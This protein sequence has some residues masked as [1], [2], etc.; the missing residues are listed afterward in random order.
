MFFSLL[1]AIFF[2]LPITRT[3]FDFP[4]KV[5]AIGS[6]LYFLCFVQHGTQLIKTPFN[7]IINSTPE[8]KNNFKE[9]VKGNKNKKKR[10]KMLL[11]TRKMPKLVQIFEASRTQWG[12]FLLFPFNHC[13]KH[14]VQLY[15]T[16][17][18][19]LTFKVNFSFFLTLFKND[20][21]VL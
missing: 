3:F 5:R 16:L 2:E 7:T 21:S 11:V 6:R 17:A 8:K 12:K 13:I 9:A 15:L 4:F 18:I 19:S 1:P 14:Q 20:F 10:W